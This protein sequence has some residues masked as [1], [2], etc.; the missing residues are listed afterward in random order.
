MH[1]AK[2]AAPSAAETAGAEERPHPVVDR[3]DQHS[4]AAGP[5]SAPTQGAASGEPRPPSA[6]MIGTALRVLV[7]EDALMDSLEHLR[8]KAPMT[9]SQ[10]RGA[11]PGTTVRPWRPP[12]LTRRWRSRWSSPT[13]RQKVRTTCWSSS[14]L[15]LVSRWPRNPPGMV[16]KAG[17]H[18]PRQ[19][20]HLVR[21]PRRL[22]RRQGPRPTHS[23]W[24]FATADSLPPRPTRPPRC[25]WS[26]RPSFRM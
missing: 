2:G 14:R 10:P 13:A 7:S 12:C 18:R 1:L 21:S 17:Q 15:P 8:L 19:T 22:R 5:T 9:P 11:K 6:A 3:P 25:S 24:T 26:S 4:W 20:S 23:S 16:P